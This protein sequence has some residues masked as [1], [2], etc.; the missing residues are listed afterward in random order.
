VHQSGKNETNGELIHEL[1]AFLRPIKHGKFLRNT[2]FY[3]E[4][5]KVDE[6]NDIGGTKIKALFTKSMLVLV[7]HNIARRFNRHTFIIDV[8][9]IAVD[10]DKLIGDLKLG[11]KPSKK[12]E[13]PLAKKLGGNHAK[14]KDELEE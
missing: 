1:I 9:L 14:N 6:Y 10:L 5:R 12:Y 13:I 4:M 3:E 8:D 7:S 11:V 2:Q